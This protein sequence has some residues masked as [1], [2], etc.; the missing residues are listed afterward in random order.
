M[1]SLGAI[2]T[3]RRCSLE[4]IRKKA[5]MAIKIGDDVIPPPSEIK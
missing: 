2:N 5:F 4:A 3:I 1:L